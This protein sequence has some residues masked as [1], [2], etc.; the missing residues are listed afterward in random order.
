MKKKYSFF[1]LTVLTMVQTGFTASLFEVETD[2]YTPMSQMVT[3]GRDYLL[4]SNA[5][6]LLGPGNMASVIGNPNI[7]DPNVFNNMPI[8]SFETLIFLKFDPN[9]I[10]DEMVASA[11]LRMASRDGIGSMGASTRPVRLSAHPVDSDVCAMKDGEVPPKK[12]YV[13][14]NHILDSVDSLVAYKDGV[15]YWNITPIVNDWILYDQ[16]DG[17]EG[18]ENLGLAVTGRGD[19]GAEDP[20]DNEH[21]KFYS[22]YAAYKTNSPMPHAVVPSLLL[23]EAPR[24]FDD[25][26]IPGWTRQSGYTVQQWLLS[27]GEGRC[28]QGME[29]DGYCDNRFGDPNVIWQEETVINGTEILNPFLTW[30]PLAG[31]EDP[32]GQPEWAD[33]VYGGI[34][35]R[36]AYDDSVLT[37]AI[38]TGTDDG[39]LKVFVQYDWYSRGT[40]EAGVSGASE[41]TPVNFYD[42]EIGSSDGYHWYRSTQVFEIPYN[43]GRVNVAFTVAGDEPYLDSFCIVTALDAELPDE[44]LRHEMDINLDGIIDL[45]EFSLLGRQW[46]QT[47]GSLYADFD[48]NGTVDAFDLCELADLWLDISPYTALQCYK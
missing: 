6:A 38:P 44:P 47:D 33:G 26:W 7:T 25:P 48:D 36:F 4:T 39:I 46:L 28:Q 40:V 35:R 19:Y 12:F 14:E 11:W 22:R 41:I 34:Y 31:S 2:F 45:D 9:S 32:N 16:T 27:A 30:H 15:C 21:V 10:P 43:P 3:Y 17:R 20:N 42:Y 5:H 13:Y 1:I 23:I 37:A 24:C 8:Q 18:S 29:P